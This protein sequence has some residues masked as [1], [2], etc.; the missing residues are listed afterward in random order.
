MYSSIMK[1]IDS[2]ALPVVC[3]GEPEALIKALLRKEPSERS[4]MLSGGAQNI[5]DADWYKGFDWAAMKCLWL[6]PP[7][8]PQVRSSVDLANFADAEQAEMPT[9]LPYTDDGTGWDKD[10]AS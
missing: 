2:V 7:F 1:G 10:F 5:K 8:R 6:E 9:F 3:K 4:P